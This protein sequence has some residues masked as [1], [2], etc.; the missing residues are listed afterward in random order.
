MHLFSPTLFVMW[1][2]LWGEIHSMSREKLPLETFFHLLNIQYRQ[3][4]S[5]IFFFM[6]GRQVLVVG[7]GHAVS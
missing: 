4:F 2:D 6:A 3:L 7:G 5:I 1:L